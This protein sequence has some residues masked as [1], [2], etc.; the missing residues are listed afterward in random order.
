MR[1]E[2]A[3]EL[4]QELCQEKI[5]KG[6]EIQKDCLGF[7]EKLV[8]QVSNALGHNRTSVVIYHYFR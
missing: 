6:E 1:A 7:D 4:Y 8:A 3:R 5:A 2:F